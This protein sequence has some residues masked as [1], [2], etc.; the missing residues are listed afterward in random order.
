MEVWACTLWKYV[1]V[2]VY[3]WLH[4]CCM[5]VK[6]YGLLCGQA[7]EVVPSRL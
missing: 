7:D 5:F 1:Y 4:A 6:G 2:L 3:C